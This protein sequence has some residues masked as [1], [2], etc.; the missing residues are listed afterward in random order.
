MN[1]NTRLPTNTEVEKISRYMKTYD[2][3][4]PK[5]NERICNILTVIAV[6]SLICMIV[7][8]VVEK[9]P[10]KY[11]YIFLVL[12]VLSF[13]GII[14]LGVHIL[15]GEFHVKPYLGG[16]FRVED[17]YV[18]EIV[19]Y[20]IKTATVVFSDMKSDEILG[21]FEI[22]NSEIEVGSHL[23]LMVTKDIKKAFSDYMLTDNGVRRKAFLDED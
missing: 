21:E 22:D 3:H 1:D 16:L 4:S 15:M 20:N 7:S 5:R 18:K 6:I 8:F 10:I 12:T 17:G 23:L 19:S 9:I 13:V 11:A 2:K 14:L